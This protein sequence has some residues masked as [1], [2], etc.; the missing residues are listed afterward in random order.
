MLRQI[1]LGSESDHRAF[2]QSAQCHLVVRSKACENVTVGGGAWL[3]TTF[4]GQVCCWLFFQ[5]VLLTLEPCLIQ[6]FLDHE[7]YSP[8]AETCLERINTTS[9]ESLCWSQRIPWCSQTRTCTR[10]THSGRIP[11]ILG[12]EV[13][14]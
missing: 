10:L 13:Q 8:L 14:L 9:G 12:T 3:G 2:H 6:G 7:D 1:T 4:Y 5:S 11:S